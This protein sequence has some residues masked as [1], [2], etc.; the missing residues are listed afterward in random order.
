MAIS[1]AHL[2]L[3]QFDESLEFA[4]QGLRK[5]PSNSF[6]QLCRIT[7][8]VRL[9]HLSDAQTT[10]DKFQAQAPEFRISKWRD[11]THNW[12]AWTTTSQILEDALRS[13][14]IPD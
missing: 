2:L 11:L 12:R 7:C 9:G 8:L 5:S 1:K 14:G 13:V 6:F 3:G 10:A 4:D